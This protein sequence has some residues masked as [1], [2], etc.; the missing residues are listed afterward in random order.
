MS[1]N[2]TLYHTVTFQIEIK[3]TYPADPSFRRRNFQ[4]SVWHRNSRRPARRSGE[5]DGEGEESER[6]EV[7]Q[8]KYGGRKCP[9]ARK[10]RGPAG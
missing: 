9:A 1:L 8:R 7:R 4:N 10:V 2:S 3:T 6:K 5:I